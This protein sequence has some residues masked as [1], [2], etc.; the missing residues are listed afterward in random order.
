MNLEKEN[1]MEFSPG[2]QSSRQYLVVAPSWSPP[3][4][5][6]RSF[7]SLQFKNHFLIYNLIVFWLY[8]RM[9]LFLTK[10]TLKYLG[11]KRHQALK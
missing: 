11:V 9:I 2:M 6:L 1:E 7:Y 8:Q 4:M 10:H 5:P 3:K